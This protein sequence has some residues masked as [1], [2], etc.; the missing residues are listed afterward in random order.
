LLL[1]CNPP[2]IFLIILSCLCKSVVLSRGIFFEQKCP[3]PPYPK[4]QCCETTQ[5][6]PACPSDKI[7]IKIILV[8]RSGGMIMSGENRCNRRETSP[9]ATLHTIKLTWIQTPA[10]PDLLDE[11]PASDGLGQD[12]TCGSVNVKV[13]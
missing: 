1:L 7:S 8:W 6:S 13:L 3:M 11:I 12:T 4:R 9:C 2:C 10:N 5:V